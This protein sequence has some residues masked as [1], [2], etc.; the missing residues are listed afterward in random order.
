MG[1]MLVP[2]RRYP[3]VGS[4]RRCSQIIFYLSCLTILLFALMHDVM[5]TVSLGNHSHVTLFVEMTAR[6]DDN[7]TAVICEYGTAANE[8]RLPTIQDAITAAQC[9]QSAGVEDV[10]VVLLPREASDCHILL[11]DPPGGVEIQNDVSHLSL[12]TQPSGSCTHSVVILTNKTHS[13]EPKGFF[14]LLNTSHIAFRGLWFVVDI[15]ANIFTIKSS[16]FI[17]IS[18]SVFI[19]S[20]GWSR[21]HAILLTN[22]DYVF[23]TECTVKRNVSH[24]EV[25]IPG[26]LRTFRSPV[27]I[28]AGGNCC[29]KVSIN[30]H[31]TQWLEDKDSNG[32]IK[33]SLVKSALY[34]SSQSTC[35][36]EAGNRIPCYVKF[37]VAILKC[38]FAGGGIK[39][40]LYSQLEFSMH[41]LK[42]GAV[43]VNMYPCTYPMFVHI[44]GSNF[45]EISGPESST[46][47]VRYLNDSDLSSSDCD[48]GTERSGYQD[49]RHLWIAQC[50]FINNTGLI[51]G[52]V[53]VRFDECVNNASLLIDQSYF[54]GNLGRQGGG[55]VF[56]H[57][58]VN[59][60]DTNCVTVVNCTFHRN[61]VFRTWGENFSPGGAVMSFANYDFDGLK[62]TK[63][64]LCFP[65][66]YDYPVNFVACNF[67]SNSGFGAYFSR[68]ISTAFY[69]TTWD[70]SVVHIISLL[71]LMR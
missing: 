32:L 69:N 13:L 16:K 12:V 62:Q 71:R 45:N 60:I 68:A 19:L 53:G 11:S 18:K 15:G 23:L 65:S 40:P 56:F 42:G 2:R 17:V 54:E 64:P 29:E 49:R 47:F 5:C 36:R 37:V 59:T 41:H 63:A 14:R 34:G 26:S 28:V 58:S 30:P 46:V 7:I 25:V 50:E 57:F 8:R 67:T 10:S 24:T 66:Q 3:S 6:A 38:T 48:V 22:S 21:Q 61:Y 31:S 9:L 35:H 20:G 44:L 39:M 70:I 51:G 4:C 55:A 1:Q 33:A 52:A 43:E 27:M